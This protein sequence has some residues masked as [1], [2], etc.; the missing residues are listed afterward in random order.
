MDMQ[1]HDLFK[2]KEERIESVKNTVVSA[3]KSL[4]RE[5]L[6]H[7]LGAKGYKM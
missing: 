7:I 5:H 4:I 2:D 3:Y 6:P 1:M